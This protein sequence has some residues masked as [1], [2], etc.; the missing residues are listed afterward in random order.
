[1]SYENRR[2]KISFVFSKKLTF[3]NLENK[4]LSISELGVHGE[5]CQ[6]ITPL[7]RIV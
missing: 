3:Q 4:I 2:E 6:D 7:L 5:I 1:M